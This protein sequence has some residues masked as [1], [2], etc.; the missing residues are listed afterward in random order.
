VARNRSTAKRKGPP[1]DLGGPCDIFTPDQLE[2]TSQ[3]SY[4]HFARALQKGPRRKQE[5]GPASLRKPGP[6]KG[7]AGDCAVDA[8]GSLAFCRFT[9][10]E[11]PAASIDNPCLAPPR[12]PTKGSSKD[13]DSVN[14]LLLTVTLLT[15]CQLAHPLRPV[16]DDSSL[17]LPQN[18]PI[19][20]W[21]SRVSPA[22]CC[23]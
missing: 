23:W 18:K 7:T 20:D 1:L 14:N 11:R 2:N 4:R 12:R 6:E 9:W 15:A 17:I 16:E 21:S 19:S 3:F 5:K 10:S 22:N 8:P 13:N